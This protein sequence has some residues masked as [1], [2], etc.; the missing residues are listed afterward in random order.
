[1]YV[2]VTFEGRVIGSYVNK[3]RKCEALFSLASTAILD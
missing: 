3:V 2:Y 1:M